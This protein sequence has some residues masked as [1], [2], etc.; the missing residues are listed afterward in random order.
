VWP[1]AFTISCIKIDFRL[2][3]GVSSEGCQADQ[4]PILYIV[5]Q[6]IT[7]AAQF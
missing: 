2:A 5:A 3:L 1:Y 4:S 7:P 6:E